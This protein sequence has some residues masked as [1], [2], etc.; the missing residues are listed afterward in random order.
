MSRLSMT[1]RKEFA[2]QGIDISIDEIRAETELKN[3]IIYVYRNSIVAGYPKAPWQYKWGPG[4]IFFIDHDSVAEKGVRVGDLTTRKI[5]ELFHTQ[6]K[7]PSDWRF[8]EG[9]ILPHSYI[10]WKY[11]ECLFGNIRTFLAFLHQRKDLEAQIDRE[12]NVKL[13]RQV[14]EQALKMEVQVLCRSLF[15]RNSITS[16]V[17]DERLAIAQKLWGERKTYSITK[18]ARVTLLDRKLLARIFKH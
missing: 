4:D 15:G 17:M 11:V 7:L 2:P 16:T 8:D 10:D 5:R 1:G 12:C 14:T 6:F 9:M 18:L 3:K 13:E